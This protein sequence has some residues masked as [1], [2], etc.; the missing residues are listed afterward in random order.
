MFLDLDRLKNQHKRELHFF[1]QNENS[2][3]MPCDKTK[4]FPFMEQ[5]S[6]YSQ[7]HKHNFCSWLKA[8]CQRG[9]RQAG[10]TAGM[11]QVS[12]C[13]CVLFFTEVSQLSFLGPGTS[14][15]AMSWLG[16]MSEWS[17]TGLTIGMPSFK[18]WLCISLSDFLLVKRVTLL[19][20]VLSA[21]RAVF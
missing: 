4:G 9:C 13:L 15:H 18:P 19:T 20:T 17:S 7:R 12:S 8:C 16:I 10:L 5:P 2:V 11:P 1:F 6:G 14:H 3:H 21:E